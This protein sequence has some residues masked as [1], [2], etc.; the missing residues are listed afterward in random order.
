MASTG[1]SDT[2]D[3]RTER[4][5][6][7][8]RSRAHIS[9]YRHCPSGHLRSTAEA[10]SDSSC[11]AFQLPSSG[12]A[13]QFRAFYLSHLLGCELSFAPTSL[14]PPPRIGI[15]RFT[16]VFL[17]ITLLILTPSLTIRKRRSSLETRPK[18]CAPLGYAFWSWRPLIASEMKRSFLQR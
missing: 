2:I 15:V 17:K 18:S 7:Q 12:N 10:A 5:P 16:S 9:S 14:R 11:D 3:Q 1:L 4:C 13:L 6:A 8:K